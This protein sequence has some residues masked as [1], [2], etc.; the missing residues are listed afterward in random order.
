MVPVAGGQIEWE[1]ERIN[2]VKS[3]NILR[4]G[5]GFSPEGRRVFP[6]LAVG[7]NLKIGG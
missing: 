6:G 1:G 4:L 3:Y 5:I 2:D 7:E